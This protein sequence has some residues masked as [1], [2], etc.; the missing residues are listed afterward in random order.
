VPRQND[1]KV[2]FM[3][4]EGK[5]FGEVLMDLKLHRPILADIRRGSSPTMGPCR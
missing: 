5:L 4:V 3:R 1:I 2:R